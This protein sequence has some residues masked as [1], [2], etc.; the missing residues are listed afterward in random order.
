[1]E[2]IKCILM[3]VAVVYA[4]RTL[5]GGEGMINGKISRSNAF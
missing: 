3:V 1:M 2:T 4:W 5:F